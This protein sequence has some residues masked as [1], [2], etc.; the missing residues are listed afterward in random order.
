MMR[1]ALPALLALSMSLPL[2]AAKHRAVGRAGVVAD[3][4]ILQTTDIHDHGNGAGHN[5]L[6]VDPV[7]ATSI[8]GAYSRI[9]S[10]INNVRA[11]AG[12]PVVLVD[13]GDGTMGPLYDLTLASKPVALFFLN[14]MK[15]DAVT[16]GN[17]EFDYTPRGLAQML[18]AA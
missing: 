15:Y 13:S 12:H 5:G 1:R 6:D 18:A 17:H 9:A 2:A 3:I 4:T 7:T 10:Y 16:L 14:S 11:T 8:I